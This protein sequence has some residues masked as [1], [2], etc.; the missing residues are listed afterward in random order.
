MLVLSRKVNERIVIGSNVQVTVLAVCGNR[1]KLGIVGP[2]DVPIH[3]QELYDR[4]TVH[5]SRRVR[6]K[7]LLRSTDE[8]PVMRSG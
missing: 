8:S 6:V 2:K 1:V 5:R 4:I 3:R 7:E